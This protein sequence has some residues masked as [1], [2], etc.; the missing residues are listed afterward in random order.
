MS[1]PKEPSFFCSYFQVV[2][3]PIDYFRLFDSSCRWRGDSSHLYLS[4]PETAPILHALF[5]EARFIVILRDPRARAHSLYRHMRRYKHE[6]GE[7]LELLESFEEALLAEEHRYTDAGFPRSCRQYF[8]NFM[9][10]RSGLYDLQ[11]ERYFKL[12]GRDKFSDLDLGRVA[13]RSEWGL[14]RNRCISQHR[15]I[16]IDGAGSASIECRSRTHRLVARGGG[17]HGFMPRERDQPDRSPRREAARLEP[18]VAF[19][20]EVRLPGAPVSQ[21]GR[22]S[23]QSLTPINTCPVD[24]ADLISDAP[25]GPEILGGESAW[26]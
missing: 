19:E 12:Y 23:A 9:Y 7:P 24:P 8:W 6:D 18:L 20:V 14:S 21:C 25:A 22:R 3:N 5:P 15:P 10:C 17:D 16:A 13:L 2:S 11:L 1:R 26:L 4:N